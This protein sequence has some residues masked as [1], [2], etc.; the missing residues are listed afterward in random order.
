MR[1]ACAHLRALACTSEACST[2]RLALC[3]L[4]MLHHCCLHLLQGDW[5]GD[6]DEPD[7]FGIM[8]PSECSC[9]GPSWRLPLLQLALHCLSCWP[10]WQRHTF[11]AVALAY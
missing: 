6:F 4:A 3:C 2:V 9:P 7:E 5:E 1:L 8:K 10:W 11:R